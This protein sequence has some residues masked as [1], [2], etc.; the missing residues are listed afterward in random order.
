MNRR[1]KIVLAAAAVTVAGL[2][3]WGA[4]T[5]SAHGWMG[6]GDGL[7]STLSQKLGVSE[8]KVNSALEELRTE[9]QAQMQAVWEEKLTSLVDEGKITEAQKQQILAKHQEMVTKMQAEREALEKWAAENGIDLQYLV[10]P[11]LM[12]GHMKM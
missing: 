4:V 12:R 1:G 5:A 11:G 10:G 2:T 8:D 9:R 6:G 3:T 7:A